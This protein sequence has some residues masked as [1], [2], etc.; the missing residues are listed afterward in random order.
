MPLFD[1]YIMVD[2]SRGSA[3]RGMQ[4]DSTWIAFGATNDLAPETLSPFSRSEATQF[5]RELLREQLSRDRR[6]LVGFDFA[7]SFPRDFSAALQAAIGSNDVT[8]PWMTIW[9]F[10][11]QEIKDD[12]GTSPDRRP[13]NRSNR[14]EVANRINALLSEGADLR[15]PF[16]CAS[17]AVYPYLPQTRPRQPFQSAQGFL[18]Q[19]LRFTDL[20]A[21][22]GTPFRLYGTA[23]VGS[24]TLTGIPRLHELRFDP[25]LGQ[26]SAIWPFETG[27]A[28]TANWLSER[29]SIV[30]AEIYPSIREPLP[31]RIKDRGQVRSMW[32]WASE[33]DRQNLLWFEFAR[34]VE[35]DPGSPEDIAIQLSEGWI[36]GCSPTVRRH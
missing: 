25:E 2:W 14:F 29:I 20:R 28:A 13:S 34:P 31:D 22:S 5:I 30:H 8:L 33:L 27:W 10:L 26:R 1:F 7:Y 32:E 6:T 4:T 18:I 23:S 35:I 17:E 24:Q 12:L 3:R 9:E 36:L 11:R 21:R 19:P 15:G 16:W